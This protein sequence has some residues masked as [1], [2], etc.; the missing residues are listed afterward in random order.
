MQDY[1][2]RKRFP[3]LGV[4]EED[5]RLARAL[6]PVLVVRLLVIQ[7]NNVNQWTPPTMPLERTASPL[8][9]AAFGSFI[10][11][12]PQQTIFKGVQ[13]LLQS[14]FVCREV[15]PLRYGR[16]VC[17]RPAIREGDAFLKPLVEGRLTVMRGVC[18][19]LMM[20]RA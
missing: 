8:L 4:V 16:L 15:M 12:M 2:L 5:V 1:R 11:S 17:L 6:R 13:H 9:K 20:V 14:F 7:W 19:V 18:C 3:G 10:P